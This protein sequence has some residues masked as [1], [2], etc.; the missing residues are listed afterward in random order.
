[1]SVNY[2]QALTREIAIVIEIECKDLQREGSE[3][4]QEILRVGTKEKQDQGESAQRE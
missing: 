3:K 2:S 4:S 1:M